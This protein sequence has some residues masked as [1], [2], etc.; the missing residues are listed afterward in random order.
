MTLIQAMASPP[1][2]EL[3]GLTKK[4][5]SLL[6]N[7]GVSLCVETGSIHAI[8]GENGAGKSTAMKMLYGL[9]GPDEGEIWV[10]G[11]KWGISGKI[12]KSPAEALASGIG[13]VHQHFMLAGPYS[14][15]EN[16]VLGT[17]SGRMAFLPRSLRPIDFSAAR[18]RLEALA[19]KLRFEVDWD[20][21]IESLPVGVQQ[22]I[23][24][25][26]LL[27]RDAEVLILDE[28][29]A[30]LTPQETDELFSNLK[31]LSRQGKTILI[32]THK[33]KEVMNLADRVTVFR[34]GKVVSDVET[35]ATDPNQLASW[36]VGRKV[37]LS[38][39]APAA[40]TLGPS[41]VS[42][43][44]VSLLRGK[45]EG[46]RILADVSFNVRSGEIVG[47]AGIEGNGQSELLRL[48]QYPEIY[49]GRL[50]GRLELL[51]R[52]IFSTE[53]K[54]ILPVCEIRSLPSAIVPEDRLSEGL[55]LQQDLRENFLLG[56]QRRAPFQRRGWVDSTV[57]E[58]K[59]TSA[60]ENYDVR[61][62]D[63]STLAGKLSG[64]NQQKLIFAREFERDPRFI[65]AAQPTRGV[66]I[67]AIE[68]IHRR[69]FDARNQG[70]AV[71]LVSSELDEILTLS[72]RI[73]VFFSGRIVAEYKR[74]EVTQDRLGLDMGG[75]S[76]PDG[77][78][79]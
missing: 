50:L 25:I 77:M 61:P 32:I 24:I 72:D 63:P 33:L 43:N 54:R 70:A 73:L 69:I 49:R 62:R 37:Q 48:I 26:K 64:G 1:A 75:G 51:G 5:G 23:E 52:E 2:V 15:L 36:M 35:R 65:L 45:R 34:A 53:S 28:P 56:L 55:L 9:Y 44:Q 17:D 76:K 7:D 10:R 78:Q 20:A 74:G 27:Y 29:T 6:A 12:W 39:E 40:P 16:V 30:V 8:I 13:M 41:V 66:D 22:R 14:A 57:L 71:L 11:R 19:K 58:G 42:L 4:F 67:G 18:L 68:S 59:L 31:I 60:L 47:I 38:V 21:P 3:R 79:A 46:T